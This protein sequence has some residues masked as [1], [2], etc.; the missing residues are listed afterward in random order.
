MPISDYSYVELTDSGKGQ[1]TEDNNGQGATRQFRVAWTDLG[2][3]IKSLKG[4]S[5]AINSSVTTYTSP[6]RH[7]DFPNLY[8]VDASY[9]G[10][11]A[12]SATGGISSWPYAKVTANYK[13]LA[14]E[15]GVLTQEEELDFSIEYETLPE[16]SLET[17]DDSTN[18]AFPH[19]KIVPILTYSITLYNQ[20][21]LPNS[22]SG[23]VTSPIDADNFQTK[24]PTDN[25]QVIYGLLGKVNS[26]AFKGAAAG[27]ML[28][29]GAKASRSTNIYGD[30]N[31]KVG[32]KF[33]YRPVSWNKAFVSSKGDYVA[34][35]TKT[36]GS[37]IYTAGNFNQ[38]LPRQ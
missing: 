21:N 26:V 13:A 5:R 15:P 36:G 38:L 29:L 27:C 16:D 11:G 20:P 25:I 18:V 33:L 1:I 23:T 3:F 9:E 24:P 32:Y 14:F 17:T 19:K 4:G 31:W 12:G 28:F 37:T 2:N 8:C 6:D 7:P 35:R 30:Q 10:I 22:T 34:V